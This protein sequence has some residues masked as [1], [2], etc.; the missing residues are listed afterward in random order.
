MSGRQEQLA[1]L[2]PCDVI[3]LAYLSALLERRAAIES[4]SQRYEDIKTFFE[5]AVSV[6]P[7]E[8]LFHAMATASP[9]TVIQCCKLFLSE[10]EILSPSEPSQILVHGMKQAVSNIRG[11]FH[12]VI[13]RRRGK[14]VVRHS[15]FGSS[16]KNQQSN[17]P[18]PAVVCRRPIRYSDMAARN[19]TRIVQSINGEIIEEETDVPSKAIRKMEQFINASQRRAV[20]RRCLCGKN[21]ECI[22]PSSEE[23]PACCK[24]PMSLLKGGRKELDLFSEKTSHIVEINGDAG[25]ASNSNTLMLGAL[26]NL[27]KEF[28]TCSTLLGAFMEAQVQVPLERRSNRYVDAIA[29]SAKS[30]GLD[31]WGLLILPFGDLKR[32]LEGLPE[33]CRRL[34]VDV[35]HSMYS[36]YDLV[37]VSNRRV[38]NYEGKLEFLL[39][40]MQES[41]VSNRGFVTYSLERQLEE[42]CR[43]RNIYDT[44]PLDEIL[45]QWQANF[46]DE[47]LTLVPDHY[48]PLVARWIKWS[49]MI[50]RLRESIAK[51]TAVGV[52]GLVNSGKSKFVRSIFGIKVNCVLF[53]T[54]KGVL[55]NEQ[56]SLLF[57]RLG[58]NRLINLV[59]FM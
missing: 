43:K 31:V 53:S 48:R 25:S 38:R 22:Y 2:S 57:K 35:T 20:R 9:H 58:L 49:L 5:D 3:E 16:S 23:N 29:K 36:L 47:T 8:S 30:F 39:T 32:V 52:I 40:S 59:Y 51:Q 42:Q 27:R 12:L 11:T 50:N 28:E 15:S 33:N 55:Y 7:I 56:L 18:E 19:R 10:S 34:I 24:A 54:L 46:E 21:L 4:E 1:K 13:Q 41:S 44:T 6:V 26:N 17:L 45:Q 37:S 14:T